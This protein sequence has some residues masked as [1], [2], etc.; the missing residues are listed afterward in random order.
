MIKA[1]SIFY[2]I[3]VEDIGRLWQ[4]RYLYITTDIDDLPSIQSRSRRLLIRSCRSVV[5]QYLLSGVTVAGYGFNLL[6]MFDWKSVF[7]IWKL[8]I[9]IISFVHSNCLII[10]RYVRLLRL[11]LWTA[12][13]TRTSTFYADG[14][15]LVHPVLLLGLGGWGI[16]DLS[17][18]LNVDVIGLVSFDTRIFPCI[19]ILHFFDWDHVVRTL[20][21]RVDVELLGFCISCIL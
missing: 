7:D 5:T 17:V 1:L 13:S 10:I 21:A 2:I 19:L 12:A 14:L 18:M 20:S 16:D 8:S 9:I 4:S 6:G 15:G 11:I 3:F